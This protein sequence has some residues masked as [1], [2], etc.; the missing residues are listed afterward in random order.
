MAN[1]FDDGKIAS[2]L[3]KDFLQREYVENR[4][5]IKD[6][7]LEVGCSLNT[8]RNY[9][10]K[11]G[12]PIESRYENRKTFSGSLN[13]A[14]E[15]LTKE[16]LIE[17][18][19]IKNRSLTNIAREMN[20]A[21]S[22]VREMLIKHGISITR[23]ES[24]YCGEENNF[25]SGGI[26]EDNGYLVIRMPYHRLANNRGY[27]RLHVILAEY[28]FGVEIQK[29]EIVHHK[30]EDKQ[31]NRKDNLQIMKKKDHDRLHTKK[32]WESEKP[33]RS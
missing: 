15:V 16:Y 26:T 7:S 6:I 4:R 31:D 24:S 19:C 10:I 32:R 30:N 3:T 13:P 23:K 29:D 14:R 17:E 28:F 33:F 25:F 11:F 8:V 21:T 27:V 18:Y 20:C 5:Y 2:I 22:L 9:L 1:Q 12:I